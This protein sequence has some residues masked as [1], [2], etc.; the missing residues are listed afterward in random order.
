M[1]KI[2]PENF[3]ESLVNIRIHY[4]VGMI[5]VN[6]QIV[7]IFTEHEGAAEGRRPRRI[8]GR[9]V[10]WVVENLRQGHDLLIRPKKD[11]PRPGLFNPHDGGRFVIPGEF[12]SIASGE[13]Q[14]GEKE[15]RL[16]AA[17][18][19]VDWEYEIEV[20][21]GRRVLAKVDPCILVAGGG[22]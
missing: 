20:R 22:A 13:P 1:P 21:K 19:P 17:R 11:N 12:N 16:L 4:T 18:K 10:R 3:E 14:L 6:P 9:K 7:E 2:E 5:D 15:N 8:Q